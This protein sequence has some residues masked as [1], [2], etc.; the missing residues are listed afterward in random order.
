MHLLLDR[1]ADPLGTLPP[2][3]F[4]SIHRLTSSPGRGLIAVRPDGYIGFR[5]QTVEIG[6]LATWLGWLGAGAAPAGDVVTNGA[7]VRDLPPDPRDR[8]R[9]SK[10]RI[11]QSCLR[12]RV[13]AMSTL[14]RCT[15]LASVAGLIG[16]AGCGTVSANSPGEA[17]TPTP[18]AS[19]TP[20]ATSPSGTAMPRP[21]PPACPQSG[22]YLTAIKVGQHAGYDRV[23]FQ[24]SGGRPAYGIDRVGTVYA[25][26][27]GTPVAL[28][29]QSFLR[30]V[31]RGATAVC[32]PSLAK[33]YAGPSTLTPFYPELLAV[34]AAGDFEGY[35]SFGIGLAAR[36]AYHL[37]TMTGPYRVVI[38]VDHVA[39]G[40]FPGIWPVT[41]WPRYW[42]L[43]YS[44]NNGHQPWQADPAMV[45]QA[46]A[47][48]RWNGTPVVRQVDAN[49]FKVTGPAARWP[50]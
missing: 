30:V 17:K 48:S 9:K 22:S 32:Q 36:G 26:P 40:A 44:W 6:Q 5:G 24:F 50:P 18:T 11:I 38:D 23:V 45:V 27:R 2:S 4:V 21:A 7:R 14:M 31:F 46:W 8:F 35:L 28:A 49:T 34:S 41:S 25:D 29:G 15:V 39:L 10:K 3:P 12:K 16:L 33:T 37:S 13:S 47:R 42:E 20:P 1:D 19:T 43:Q